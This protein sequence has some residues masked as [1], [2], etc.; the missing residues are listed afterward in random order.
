MCR[1]LDTRKGKHIKSPIGI[2]KKGAIFLRHFW[3][4]Q[5]GFTSW[6]QHIGKRCCC[7]V[8]QNFGPQNL[9]NLELAYTLWAQKLSKKTVSYGHPPYP[10][11]WDT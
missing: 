1:L 6:F 11:T 2:E 8:Y 7:T 10:T 9:Q 4:N 5:A 3:D